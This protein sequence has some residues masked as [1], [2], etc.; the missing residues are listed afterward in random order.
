MTHSKS[1]PEFSRAATRLANAAW[2]CWLAALAL[3]VLC[4]YFDASAPYRE[5]RGIPNDRIEDFCLWFATLAAASGIVTSGV[6]WLVIWR[7][8]SGFQGSFRLSF[9]MALNLLTLL[10]VLFTLYVRE[11][12]KAA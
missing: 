3:G 11:L 9:G 10:A 1:D 5:I 6:G 2:L 8:A 12:L 7:A 4:Y